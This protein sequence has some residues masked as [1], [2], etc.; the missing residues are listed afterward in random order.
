MHYAVVTFDRI[1]L[2]MHFYN[3]QL[4][5]SHVTTAILLLK[6]CKHKQTCKIVTFLALIVIVCM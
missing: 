6:Y 3:V 5:V 2:F 1:G 4:S